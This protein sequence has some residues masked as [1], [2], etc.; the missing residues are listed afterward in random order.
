MRNSPIHRYAMLVTAW[1]LVL[2]ISGAAVTSVERPAP[3]ATLGTA[4]E[5]WHFMLAIGAGL[6]I[7]ILAIWL[8][9]DSRRW[10]RNFGWILF[11]ATILEGV[12]GQWSS[13]GPVVKIPQAVLAH[14]LFAATVAIAL[15]TSPSWSQG[16]LPI[17]DTW[18]P[19]LNSL[20]L[21]MPAVVLLQIALGAAYRFRSLSVLWHI[22]NA[23]IV[24]LLLLVVAMFLI[25]QF[26][27][28]S[29]LRPAAVLVA[30]ITSTQVALGFTTFLILL[31]S[32]NESSSAVVWS[33]TAHV[34]LGALTLAA[35]VVLSIQIRYHRS[36]GGH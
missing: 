35:S 5:R 4:L 30:V 16:P 32:P 18:R 21:W 22:L 6:L 31:L 1:V 34:A 29:S 36:A 27:Q 3:G 12:L 10:L 8:S 19:S 17:E 11:A 14:L 9:R 23:M 28:H 2:I 33:S 7:L 15:F 20:S 26:P 24:L 25:R 13:L